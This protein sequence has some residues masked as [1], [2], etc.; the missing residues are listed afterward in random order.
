MART[1]LF[2]VRLAVCRPL[3]DPLA[4]MRPH[5]GAAASWGVAWRG[6][7]C[8]LGREPLEKARLV[9]LVVLGWDRRIVVVDGDGRGGVRLLL[10]P[11]NLWRLPLEMCAPHVRKNRCQI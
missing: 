8:R 4:L 10:P 7:R 5:L 1:D 11:V 3:L 9:P 6:Y 2:I